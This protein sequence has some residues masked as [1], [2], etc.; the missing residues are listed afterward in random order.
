MYTVVTA[1]GCGAGG[2]VGVLPGCVGG[3]D[4]IM[5]ELLRRLMTS[6]LGSST[7]KLFG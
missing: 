7:I 4:R 5:V 6:V 2:C 1:T 3:G